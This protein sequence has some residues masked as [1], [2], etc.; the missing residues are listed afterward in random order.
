MS[1]R[2][3][4]QAWIAS[5]ASAADAEARIE[6]AID[7][8]GLP[9]SRSANARQTQLAAFLRTNSANETGWT[10]PGAPAP[11]GGGPPVPGT[12]PVTPQP[13]RRMWIGQYDPPVECEL[14]ADDTWWCYS[15]HRNGSRPFRG[16]FHPG[17]D[18]PN[19]VFAPPA[20]PQQGGGHTPP[21]PAQDHGG[22]DKPWYDRLDDAVADW[23]KKN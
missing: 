2:G 10:I 3:E 19:T 23:L 20:A 12:P 11:G 16:I 15:V 18:D 13:A 6:Q 1:T 5:A 8:L 17:V 9:K 7:A 14:Q 21:P 4:I 22:H